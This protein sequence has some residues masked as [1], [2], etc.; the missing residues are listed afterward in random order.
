MSKLMSACNAPPLGMKKV[1]LT[2]RFICLSTDA[3]AV[4]IVNTPS[5]VGSGM[6]EAFTWMM[7]SEPEG[8]ANAE[9]MPARTVSSAKTEASSTMI[10]LASACARRLEAKVFRS[11]G[12]ILVFQSE[13][14]RQRRGILKPGASDEGAPPLDHVSTRACGALKGRNTACICRPYRPDGAHFFGYQ[15]RRASRLPLAFIFRAV[16]AQSV[17]FEAKPSMAYQLALCLDRCRH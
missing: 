13:I 5:A 11:I 6:S 10:E 12:A 2:G 17:T 14:E 1:S 9:R 3:V 7:R 15:G 16:G 8:R 4:A